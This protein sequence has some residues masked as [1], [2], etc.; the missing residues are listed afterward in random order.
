MVVASPD[1]GCGTAAP[2]FRRSFIATA[3][4]RGQARGCPADVITAIGGGVVFFL[5]RSRQAIGG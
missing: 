5:T 1:R 3:G 4:S 2:H